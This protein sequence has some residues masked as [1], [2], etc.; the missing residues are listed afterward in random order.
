M[1]IADAVREIRA[2]AKIPV[3]TPVQLEAWY[4]RSRDLKV[5]LLASDLWTQ[6]PHFVAH[7]LEDADLRARSVEYRAAQD[8]DLAQALSTWETARAV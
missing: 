1:T 4:Q 3:D 5:T 8:R 7:Y 6:M 2:L